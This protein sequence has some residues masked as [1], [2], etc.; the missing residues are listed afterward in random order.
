[1]IRLSASRFPAQGQ[2]WFTH[3]SSIARVGKGPAEQEGDVRPF[4]RGHDDLPHRVFDVD[5]VTR[6]N[7]QHLKSEALVLLGGDTCA[8]H[9]ARPFHAAWGSGSQRLPLF[10]GDPA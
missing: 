3:A 10:E 5:N 1:M 7:S 2:G 4:W 9:E 6:L 8:A